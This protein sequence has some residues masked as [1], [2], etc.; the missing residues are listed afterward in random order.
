MK[1]YLAE[2]K[3]SWAITGCSIMADSWNDAHGRK[4]INFLVSCPRGV[5]F[6]SSVDATDIIEDA[7][8]LFK[9]L[10]KAVDEVG[11]EYVVQVIYLYFCFSVK[12]TFI[13]V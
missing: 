10:D 12:S 11:E 4:L 9:L 2:F 1:E 8:N 7:A 6:L 5:Y 3:A 13:T